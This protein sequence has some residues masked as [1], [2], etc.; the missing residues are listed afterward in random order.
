MKVIM[1][2]F[3]VFTLLLVS[4]SYAQSSG[5]SIWG[6]AETDQG[7]CQAEA[8][9]MA[10]YKQFKHVGPCI[11][12]FEGIGYGGSSPNLKTCTPKYKMTLTGDAVAQTSTGSWVRVR[13]W[14]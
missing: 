11:G 13:S 10:K 1:F 3:L 9:Y 14:R 12:R 6:S 2:K 4:A 8:N 7:R 5:N